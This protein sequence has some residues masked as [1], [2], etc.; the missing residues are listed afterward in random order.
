MAGEFLLP[1]RTIS[2]F[3]IPQSTGADGLTD[4]NL[5]RIHQRRHPR[6]PGAL[7]PENGAE[8][9]FLDREHLA[10][11]QG[12]TLREC[13]N[14]D[15]YQPLGTVQPAPEIIILAICPAE[16]GSEVIELDAFQCRRRPAFA[17]RESIFG[18]DPID[19]DWIEFIL[20]STVSNGNVATSK[21]GKP[22]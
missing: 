9:A 14:N 7:L 21:K 1:V 19:L 18:R 2:G 6:E 3:P 13:G 22:R 10:G 11:R 5:Q 20:P 4:F 8:Q 12:F 16:E 17:D 15:V